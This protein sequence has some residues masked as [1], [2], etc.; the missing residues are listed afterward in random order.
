M[1]DFRKPSAPII[2]MKHPDNLESNVAQINHSSDT[3]GSI[4]VG[5]RNGDIISYSS[6]SLNI[7]SWV[8][9]TIPF[10]ENELLI[11]RKLIQ[12]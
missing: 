1:W 6:N 3:M 9:S 10:I 5:Y 8:R 7:P 2:Q 11:R 4:I 12:D